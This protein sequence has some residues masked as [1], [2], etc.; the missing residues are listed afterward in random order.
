MNLVE[1]MK[2]HSLNKLIFFE[3]LYKRIEKEAKEAKD[4]RVDDPGGVS[5]QLQAVRE[6][7]CELRKEQGIPIPSV[8][9]KLKTVGLKVQGV[10]HG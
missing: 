9:V 1:K 5:E 10:D 8:T 3:R 4:P 2:R 6:A 7:I